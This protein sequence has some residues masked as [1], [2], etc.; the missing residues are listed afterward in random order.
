MRKIEDSGKTLSKIRFSSC[1][2][3]RSW[4]KGFSTMTRAP[5]A[6]PDFAKLLD[7]HLK[8]HRRNGQVMRG[9]LRA[10]EFLA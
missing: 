9:M 8:Q 4:P 2:D 1:A 10:V 5:L 7:H 3:A 6:Q